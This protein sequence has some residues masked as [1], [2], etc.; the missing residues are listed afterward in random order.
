MS[1][2]QPFC[3]SFNNSGERMYSSPCDSTMLEKYSADLG[4]KEIVLC[5]DLYCDGI[6]LPASGSQSISPPRFRLTNVTGLDAVWFDIGF[7]PT[8]RLG[9]SICS[10]AKI[11]DLRSELLHRYLYLVLH[12]LIEAS[13]IGF[14]YDDVVKFP[15]I[16]MILSDQKKERP[17]V[18]LKSSNSTRNCTACEILS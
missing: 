2:I 4:T 15:R 3:R 6:A 12:P 13:N 14:R 9:N 7:C 5:V 18:G 11:T 16:L 10:D 8:L 1:S 17:L